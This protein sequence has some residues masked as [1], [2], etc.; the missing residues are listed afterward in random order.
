VLKHLHPMTIAWDR[1]HPNR[2]GHMVLA[3]AFLKAVGA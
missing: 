3:Q 1:V 2:I